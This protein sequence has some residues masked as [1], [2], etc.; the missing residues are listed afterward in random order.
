[1]L[2]HSI[3][4]KAKRDFNPDRLFYIV[5]EWLVKR[6]GN[7]EFT[8]ED[9]EV[10]NKTRDFKIKKGV[11]KL[12]GFKYCENGLTFAVCDYRITRKNGMY[13]VSVMVQRT[14]DGTWIFGELHTFSGKKGSNVQEAVKAD[15]PG[16]FRLLVRAAGGGMNGTVPMT[17]YPVFTDQI[18]I[19][20]AF[21]SEES[22]LLLPVIRI[23]SE[24][25]KLLDTKKVSHL[26]FGKASVV[27]LAD[28]VEKSSETIAQKR[29]R[30]FSFAAKFKSRKKESI[31]VKIMYP[32]GNI[33]I[34]EDRSPELE[35]S[36]IRQIMSTQKRQYTPIDYRYISGKKKRVDSFNYRAP[37]HYCR[38]VFEITASLT[39]KDRRRIKRSLY[40]LQGKSDLQGYR[41][42]LDDIIVFPDDRVVF[43]RTRMMEMHK[44]IDIAEKEMAGNTVESG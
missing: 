44:I 7:S 23:D 17:E 33:T 41:E 29:F 3:S 34:V 16:I 38:T 26:L 9:F 4:F 6:S 13:F 35:D 20:T 25:A 10:L 1:M 37:N 39:S 19:D 30:L 31:A 43:A 14:M 42:V 21:S 8:E 12:S 40:G 18:S 32:G 22:P 27:V 15:P 28:K 11:E 2:R 5:K 24:P 36:L